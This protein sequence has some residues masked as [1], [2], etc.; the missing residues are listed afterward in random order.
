MHIKLLKAEKEHLE[1]VYQMIC[2]LE[3][4]E[5][6]LKAFREVYLENLNNQNISYQLIQNHNETV[7]F[8]SIHLQKLLHHTQTIAEIQEFYIAPEFRCKGIGGAVIQSIKDWMLS[9]HVKQME[10]CTNKLREKAREFY[11]KLSF[12]ESHVKFTMVLS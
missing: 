9:N 5:L 8:I 11:K 6:D 1:I 12:Q 10:V 2:D 4:H 3:N 7:G